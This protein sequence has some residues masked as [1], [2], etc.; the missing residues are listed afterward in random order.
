M[1]S[2]KGGLPAIDPYN[3]E[4]HWYLHELRRDRA[5][6][7]IHQKSGNTKGLQKELCKLRKEKYK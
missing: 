6:K 4:R 7:R 3:I 5:F 2:D 1:A